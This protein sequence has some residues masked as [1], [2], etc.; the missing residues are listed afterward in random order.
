[1]ALQISELCFA[2]GACVPECPFDAIAKTSD[3]YEILDSKCVDC[4]LCLDSCP[5]GA[6]SLADYELRAVYG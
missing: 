1:M 2:C 4:L 5:P 6:I 3:K